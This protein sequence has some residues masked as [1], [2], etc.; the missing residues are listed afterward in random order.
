VAK[1]RNQHRDHTFRPP[2][3]E[4]QPKSD[5]ELLGLVPSREAERGVNYPRSSAELLHSHDHLAP[6]VRDHIGM[7]ASQVEYHPDRIRIIVKPNDE[8][9]RDSD[10]V[11]ATDL[12]LK[13]QLLEEGVSVDKIRNLHIATGSFPIEESTILLVGD[14]AAVFEG[15][16]GRPVVINS[17]TQALPT[18]SIGQDILENYF[19]VGKSKDGSRKMIVPSTGSGE[20]EQTVR[21]SKERILQS[22]KEPLRQSIISSRSKQPVLDRIADIESVYDPMHVKPEPMTSQFND[23]AQKIELVIGDKV[24][25]FYGI[26]RYNNDTQTIT[27]AR[28]YRIDPKGLNLELYDATGRNR[29]WRWVTAKEATRSGIMSEMMYG[30]GEKKHKEK[31]LNSVIDRKREALLLRSPYSLPPTIS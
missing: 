31:V 18:E 25:V 20:E 6:E 2:R 13:N 17:P 21:I 4:Q 27:L 3:R 10:K 23:F 7:F 15:G 14:K 11:P 5:W 12:P 29:P 1:R 19:I 22:L 28:P 26:M 16:G 30:L 24:E 9:V 8:L